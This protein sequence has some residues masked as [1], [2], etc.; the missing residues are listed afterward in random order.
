MWRHARSSP[1]L[2]VDHGEM[3]VCRAHAAGPNRV[4]EGARVGACHAA[5]VLVPEEGVQLAS[6]KRNVPDAGTEA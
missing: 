3:V 6:R 5:Q 4:V 1:E 2:A